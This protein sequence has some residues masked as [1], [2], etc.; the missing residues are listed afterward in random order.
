MYSGVSTAGTGD[1][2]LPRKK[3]VQGPGEQTL[4]GMLSGLYLPAVIGG[5]AEAQIDEIACHDSSK[6]VKIVK[7]HG[8]YRSFWLNC[9]E[10]NRTVL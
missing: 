7:E 4:Y 9:R 10:F 2:E 5:A 8:L 3:S 1:G 6:N